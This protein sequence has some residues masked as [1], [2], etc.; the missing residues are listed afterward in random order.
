MDAFSSQLM[1]QAIRTR[2]ARCSGLTFVD[3]EHDLMSSTS[4]LYRVHK[5]P[6]TTVLKQAR[7]R[8]PTL[9]AQVPSEGFCDLACR[10][11]GP[12]GD[13][14]GVRGHL[15]ASIKPDLPVG[16]RARAPGFFRHRLQGRIEVAKQG[17]PRL[18]VSVC[19]PATATSTAMSPKSP[20]HIYSKGGWYD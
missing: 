7:A 10:I 20:K 3:R 15:R 13:S 1:V 19:V 8:A 17:G 9:R 11:I 14:L 4:R 6:R 5:P 18:R 12:D 2:A 16:N